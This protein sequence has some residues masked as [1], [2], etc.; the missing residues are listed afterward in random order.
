MLILYRFASALSRF[1]ARIAGWDGS[2]RGQA[3]EAGG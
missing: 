3:M 1:E 2:G